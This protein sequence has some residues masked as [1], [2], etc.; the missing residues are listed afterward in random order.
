M[1][2][3]TIF[4]SNEF[5][6]FLNKIKIPFSKNKKITNPPWKYKNLSNFFFKS[7]ILNKK[8][9]GMIV[10]SKHKDNFHINFLYVL[11]N[12]RNKR[13]GTKLINH[14][15]SHK[16]KK[17]YTVHVNKKL[18]QAIKFYKKFKFKEY[19]KSENEK[20]NNFVKKSQKFNP[21]VYKTKKLLVR[22]L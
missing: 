7:F 1:I 3:K 20:V 6:D 21:N 4:N 2:K 16:E 13:V 17:I 18:K 5:I 8:I 14:F 11:S 9:K 22:N 10:Y 12:K 15:L 19:K